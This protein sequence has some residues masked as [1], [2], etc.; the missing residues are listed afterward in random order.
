VS[1]YEYDGGELDLFAAA[2][3]WKRYLA[4]S[5]G[6]W[7][8]PR[9]LEVGAGIGATTAALATGSHDSWVCLEP[10]PSLAARLEGAHEVGKVPRFCRVVIGTTETLAQN[11]SA[12]RFDAILY[13]DVLEHINDDRAELERAADLLAPG[14]RLI[15]VSPAHQWLY[16]AFDRAI[17]HCRRYTRRSLA[18]VAPVELH[19][20]AMDYLDS[21]GLVASTANRLLLRQSMPT[22][23][24]I[25]IWNR[26]LVPVSRILDPLTL[27]SLGKSVLGVWSSSS[28]EAS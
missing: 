10:D 16:S 8:G 19:V 2:D 26:V 1:S 13:I 11:E 14:G 7:L 22:A 24:Q 17:G 12:G 3:R 18:R 4:H 5:I 20:R 28:G 15:V 9:V 21:A 23:S 6:P 25:A 27:F